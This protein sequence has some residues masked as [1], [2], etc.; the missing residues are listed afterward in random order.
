MTGF[1]FPGQ[2]SQ[3]P[4]MGKELA[5]TYWEARDVFKEADDTLGFSLSRMCFEGPKESLVLTEN[6]QPALLTVSVAVYTVLK[7]KGKIPDFVAGHSLGEYSALV[8]AGALTFKDAVQ[9]VR[10]RGQFMQEAVPVG[11]GAMAALIGLDIATVSEICNSVM[12]DQV[13][14]PANQNSPQQI[15]IAG[16]KE[17]V[18]RASRAAMERG[19]RRVIP[20]PVSA[21]FHCSLMDPAERRMAELLHSIE[22]R[23]PVIPVINNVGAKIVKTA[24]EVRDGL[25]RQ[26]SSM[27]RWTEGIECMVGAGVSSI[28][29][30]GAG[31]VLTGLVKKTVRNIE[32]FSIEKPE[33]VEAYVQTG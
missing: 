4:G 6:T 28:V 3:Y 11:V 15:A 17:A 24:E 10:K 26:I 1:V 19:A 25:I 20:I 27:V 13:I 12:E 22:I 8:A 9:L 7:N 29:E 14:T 21:P 5:D 32:L 18:E 2:G 33:Q 30:V 31:R 16:H 23:N